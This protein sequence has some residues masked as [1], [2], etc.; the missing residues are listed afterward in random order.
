LESLVFGLTKEASQCLVEFDLFSAARRRKLVAIGTGELMTRRAAALS[1]QSAPPN[2]QAPLQN[3][4]DHEPPH[5]ERIRRNKSGID[6][7]IKSGPATKAPTS[8]GDLYLALQPRVTR[9]A[10]SLLGEAPTVEL[11]HD[12]CVNAALSAVRFRGDS[13]FTSWL[14]A[15]VARHVRKWI[16]TERRRRSLMH[17]VAHYSS[18]VT[19]LQPDDLVSGNRLAARLFEALKVLSDRQRTCV[20]QVQVEGHSVND[21]ANRLGISPDAVRMNVHRARNHL[22]SFIEVNSETSD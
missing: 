19:S 6:L 12:V 8:A 21:V 17:E 1:S 20:I 22:R 16:R 7:R 15:V 10:R 18:T 5:S 4:R 11:V 14:Y 9:I 2:A 13:A 3:I